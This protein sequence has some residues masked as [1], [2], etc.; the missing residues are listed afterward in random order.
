LPRR[1]TLTDG[2]IALRAPSLDDI[3][4]YARSATDPTIID[5]THVR[6]DLGRDGATR[7]VVGARDEWEA[8]TKARFAVCPAD[9]MSRL[10]GSISLV[11]IV[12]ANRSAELGYWMLP[13]ARGQGYATRAVRLVQRWAFDVVGLARLDAQVFDSNEASRHILEA[14][15]FKVVAQQVVEHRGKNRGERLLQVG[16]D[17]WRHWLTR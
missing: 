15:G 13:E 2:V 17:E 16:R 3:A 8:G 9:S 5:F 6:L 10:L 14:S 1:T 7:F 4:D 11:N 12:W